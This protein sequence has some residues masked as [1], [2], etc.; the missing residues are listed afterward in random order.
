MKKAFNI[1]LIVG[2]LLL[3]HFSTDVFQVFISFGIALI[4][5]SGFAFPAEEG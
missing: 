3:G 5:L 2:G 1:V 4:G